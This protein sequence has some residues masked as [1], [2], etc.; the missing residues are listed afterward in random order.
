M[1][2]FLQTA[3]NF[4]LVNATAPR[5]A[6]YLADALIFHHLRCCNSM[7][8][9]G[10]ALFRECSCEKEPRAKIS[11]TNRA[12]RMHRCELFGFSKTLP[13][14]FY[15]F[16]LFLTQYFLSSFLILAMQDRG[17][18]K[19]YSQM[20]YFVIF[21]SSDNNVLKCDWYGFQR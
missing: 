10:M 2:N 21:S 3:L 1:T 8:F 12:N 7:N 17:L 9:S 16:F 19:I 11:G 18:E 13:T 6:F 14:S 4:L 20:V 15:V 5:D